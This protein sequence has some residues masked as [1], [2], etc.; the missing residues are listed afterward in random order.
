MDIHR[1]LASTPLLPFT[2]AFAVGIVCS[3][4]GF[5]LWAM[6][7]AAVVALAVGRWSIYSSLILI[8]V[9]FGSA[10]AEL[11]I[12]SEPQS[13]FNG[14]TFVY[15]GE[16]VKAHESGASQVLTIR[17]SSA[18]PRPDSLEAIA[19]FDAVLIYPEF[20]P[21]IQP[22]QTLVFKASLTPP[23]PLKDL[24]DEIDYA[25]IYAR[26]GIY[27]TSFISPEDIVSIEHTP[28]LRSWSYDRQQAIASAI[29]R[30]ALSTRAK[31][32]LTAS[33][34]GDSS[35][36]STDIREEL[37]KTGLAHLLAISGLHLAIIVMIVSIA[38]WPLN[39]I[40]LRV[41]RWVGV[42]VIIWLF[43][44]VTGLPASVVRA[45]VMSTVFILANILQ[46]RY[47][48]YNALCL[49]AL[50]ILLF[51]P[52]ALLQA[53][54]QLSFAA[55]LAILM[56]AQKLNPVSQRRR[57]LY[58]AVSTLTVS[59]SAMIGTAV[60]SIFYFHSFAVYFLLANVLAVIVMP[61]IIAGGCIIV[62]LQ[63]MGISA[64]TICVA[65]SFL[66]DAIFTLTDRLTSLPMSH[67]DNIYIPAWTIIPAIALIA[68]LKLALEFPRKVSIGL[69]AASA[70]LFIIC[71]LSLQRPEIEQRIYL[72]RS[73]YHTDLIYPTDN[74]TLS[75]ITTAPTEPLEVSSRAKMRYS[76]Y[77]GR[78][79][80]TSIAVDTTDRQSD[81]LLQIG[82]HIIGL[83]SG[84]R[85]SISPRKLDYAIVCRG[86]RAEMYELV[87]DYQPD[88]II[89]S[90]DLH[91]KRAE[92][93]MRDCAENGW[94]AIWLRKQPWSMS[95]VSQ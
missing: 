34:A 86:F 16:I 23:E 21:E 38:L 2:I 91:P 90:Y 79:N 49:A 63:F 19:S 11:N 47:S 30:S 61:F 5:G 62:A 50:L 80:L 85:N 24:P 81:K 70:S 71:L 28:N 72:S 25:D 46:R 67:I 42:L 40:G 27:L 36:L 15:H 20:S 84:K 54:F 56:F 33:L 83:L 94:P 45:S 37:S 3:V 10:T 53:G 55:V 22:G 57:W 35:V 31:E 32:F 75:I 4:L 41:W 89:L 13:Y 1:K 44:I 77:M 65:V 88:T 51:D 69:F 93:Y 26:R 87:S 78:R 73:T 68:T 17:L 39:L 12:P 6:A 76:E 92:R 58:N 52:A 14:H 8:S 43:A 82:G 7:V 74:S 64:S 66:I 59:I 60:I 9:V 48:S 18:G 29:A 95:T